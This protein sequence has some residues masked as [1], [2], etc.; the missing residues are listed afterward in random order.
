MTDRAGY[1]F[2]PAR[3]RHLANRP[4]AET[5]SRILTAKRCF[6]Q[7]PDPELLTWMERLMIS[8]LGRG[9]SVLDVEDRLL[10][11]RLCLTVAGFTTY[12]YQTTLKH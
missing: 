12:S 9:S 3:K 4:S 5:L 11:Y 2:Y 8:H 6:P 10:L 1:E 7:K